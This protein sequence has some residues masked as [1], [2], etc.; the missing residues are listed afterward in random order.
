MLC[1]QVDNRNKK[2]SSTI[3]WNNKHLLLV[4]THILG[5]WWI[6]FNLAHCSPVAKIVFIHSYIRYDVDGRRGGAH[7]NL[8]AVLHVILRGC[9]KQT[10]CKTVS[11]YN[12][13][14]WQI[15]LIDTFPIRHIS[16]LN[17]GYRS[18]IPHMFQRTTLL[19]FVLYLSDIP[20]I[21]R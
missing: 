1:Y 11:T 8:V 17:C 13:S 5:Q 18:S 21:L 2:I 15:M 10:R 4:S 14:C 19:M 9:N 7:T 6:L 12:F 16:L 20:P 3:Y